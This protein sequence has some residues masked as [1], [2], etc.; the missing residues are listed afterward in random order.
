MKPLDGMGSPGLVVVGLVFVDDD[1]V[2][3][4]LLHRKMMT[5]T[6]IAM[7]SRRMQVMAMPAILPGLRPENKHERN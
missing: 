1:S 6:T 3:F 5:A 2:T 4:G 7:V